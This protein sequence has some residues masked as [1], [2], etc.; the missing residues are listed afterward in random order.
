M[1]CGVYRWRAPKFH[2]ITPIL[3]LCTAWLKINV[4]IKYEVLSL[5]HTNINLSKLIS[6]LNSALIFHSVQIVVAY[7]RS[8]SLI[9]LR[10]HSLTSRLKIANKSPVLW[11][12]VSHLICVTLLIISDVGEALFTRP[13]PRPR[14]RPRLRPRQHW[15]DRG[16]A[17]ENQA[18]AKA[19][20]SKKTC[21]CIKLNSWGNTHRTRSA[22]I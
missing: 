11:N 18:E 6:L 14:P 13:R 4:R 21:K 7:S 22:C 20:P 19:R 9:T 12:T 17:A 10:R 2:H 3:N 5:S 1:F 8:S 16:E 15:R